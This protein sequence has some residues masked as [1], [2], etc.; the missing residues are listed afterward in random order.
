MIE[1]NQKSYAATNGGNKGQTADSLPFSRRSF[2]AKTSY[3]GALYAASKLLSMPALARGLAGDTRVSATPIVDK[4]FA[5]VRKIGEGLYATI[6]D[7]SKGFQT[8]CNGGFLTGKDGALLIE[9]FISAPGAAFQM[10]AVRMVSQVPVKFALDTHYHYDHSLGNSFYGANGIPLWAHPD[11]AEHIVAKYSAMQ[12]DGKTALLA[13]LE[14][15]VKEAKTEAARQHRESALGAYTNVFNATQAAVL[16]LPNHPIDLAA[17][18][19]KVDL[20]GLTAIIEHYPGH[21]GTDMIVRVPEQNV[22]YTGDLL[23][24]GLFPVTFDQ[25]AT[26]SGWRQTLKTFASWDKDT[27]FVPGHGPLC[28]QEG[29]A[30]FRSLFDDIEE[31]AQK[32]HKT[33]VPADEARKLYV[34]PEKFKNISVFAWDFSIGPTILKLYGEWGVK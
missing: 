1:I 22:V 16:S 5:S 11:T 3:L 31:Q 20:G 34:I 30:L 10:D 26:V 33:G 19:L 29:V 7:P 23:F 18:P 15:A 6:S 12:R 25:Q 13:P 4:G 21:S 32:L 27:L 28:G 9:G 8:L 17:L 2:L 24:S 14:K